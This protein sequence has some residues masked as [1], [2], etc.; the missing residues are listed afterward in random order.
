MMMMV[1]EHQIKWKKNED[2]KQK[3]LFMVAAPYN[4]ENVNAIFLLFLRDANIKPLMT[5][6]AFDAIGVTMNDT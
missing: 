4:E 2:T 3:V 1:E 5:S 6:L